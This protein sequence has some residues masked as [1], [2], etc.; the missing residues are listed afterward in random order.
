MNKDLRKGGSPACSGRRAVQRGVWLERCEIE[1]ERAR[2]QV[3]RDKRVLQDVGG[4]I[5]LCVEFRFYQ[6]KSWE[7]IRGFKWHVMT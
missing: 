7:T 3:K 5:N 4:P 1:E 2:G 6:M